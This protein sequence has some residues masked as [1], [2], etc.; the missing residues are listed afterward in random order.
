MDPEQLEDGDCK[1]RAGNSAELPSTDD[2]MIDRKKPTCKV[3]FSG[4][5][6]YGVWK[7]IDITVSG[8]DALSGAVF[9]VVIGISTTNNM[10]HLYLPE[11]SVADAQFYGAQGR[12]WRITGR[13]V[14]K[15]GNIKNCGATLRSIRGSETLTDASHQAVRLDD[16]PS[17]EPG[18][19]SFERPT[20]RHPLGTSASRS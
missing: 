14:D 4:K 8:N 16:A 13:V 18:A 15:A 20:G 9:L 1:D 2:V 11:E 19:S 12:H 6:N 5:A 17:D 7:W 10:D 3:Q